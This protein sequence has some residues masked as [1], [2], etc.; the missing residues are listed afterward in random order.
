MAGKRSYELDEESID[1]NAAMPSAPIDSHTAENDWSWLLFKTSSPNGGTV[2]QSGQRVHV[3]ILDNDA[4]NKYGWNPLK[5][6]N[7]RLTT[8]TVRT[9]W[10]FIIFKV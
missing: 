8:D 10:N 9:D 6:V 7:N 5:V 1:I 3:Q 4:K 2:F